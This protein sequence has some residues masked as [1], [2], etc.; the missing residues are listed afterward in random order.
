[1]T[2][3]PSSI[4]YSS[5]VSRD[6]VRIAFILASLNGLSLSAT[7]IGNAYLN[8]EAR[9]KVYTTAGPEFGAELEGNNVLIVR[10]LY[11]LKSSGAAWRAHLAN[12]LHSLGYTSCLADPD[13]WFR[14]ATKECGFEYYEYVLVYVD[15]L[16]VL[17][18]HPELTMKALESFY[19]L[20]DGFAEPNRYLGAEV[21]KWYFPTDNSK[22]YWALSSSQYVQEAIKNVENY[23]A[24]QNKTLKKSNQPFPT[25]YRPELDISPLLT[26]D[27]VHY[28]QSQLSI[29]RWMVELGRLDIYIN[30]AMLSSFLLQP[31]EGHLNA[32][33]HIYGYL[34]AHTRST[35]VFDDGYI[36]WNDDEFYTADWSEFYPGAIEDVPKNAPP[37][38]GLPVQFNV[39]VDADHAGNRMTRRSQ[40]GILLYLNK[41][42]IIWYSKAQRTVETSTFGSEFV[43]MKV[44]VEIIK[45]L[46]YKLRMM[47]VPIHG[48]ANVL[49]D[50]NTMVKNSTV[51]SQTIHKK[52]NAICY[53]FVRE[54]VAAN[55]IRIA[56]IPTTENLV[57][58]FTKPL[59]STKLHAFIQK[60]LY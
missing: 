51:P 37:P 7:D 32:I 52:H 17:S 57:D 59:G 20:K 18:H 55:I 5:V 2:D 46:R 11:G 38:R 1:M 45:G 21:K 9:E 42:P 3:P 6:S 27:S 4:T 23:L 10:A 36:H 47:G 54:A 43:A 25:E 24:T 44:A 34:K 60:I 15:D 53:H 33:F 12:T 41:A 13:V 31:R 14:S 50:N 19:R 28:Y 30:V 48:P 49:A 8:A 26:E 56:Y 40:T 39:F 29:L 22:A 58:M 35:M 16:L